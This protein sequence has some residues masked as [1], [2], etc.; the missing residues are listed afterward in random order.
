MTAA[1]SRHNDPEDQ[2][3]EHSFDELTKSVANG[4]L[5]RG[6]LLKVVGA[7]VLGSVLNSAL[8]GVAKA[9]KH[10]GK[11]ASHKHKH[12]NN[13][14]SGCF[15]GE[16]PCGS[17]GCCPGIATCCADNPVL[18]CCGPG[19][20]CCPPPAGGGQS[21]CATPDECC[22]SDPPC[23]TAQG[24]CCTLD[25]P[26]CCPAELGGGCCPTIAPQCCPPEAGGGCCPTGSICIVEGGV[27]KC[28]GI[29]RPD[30]K[31]VSQAKVAQQPKGRQEE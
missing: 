21:P 1:D 24:G 23:S 8:P 27:G 17:N 12:H 28:A 13:S 20:R 5:S 29:A 4:A 15:P 19:K 22:P 9:K 7:A 25:H 18:S 16:I 11:H 31:G 14:P 6:Q 10:K 2:P 3:T 26:L 30:S